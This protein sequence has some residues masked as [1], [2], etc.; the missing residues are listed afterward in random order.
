[1]GEIGNQGRWNN[2][3]EGELP[4]QAQ[5]EK[6]A[7]DGGEDQ[8]HGGSGS[9]R[10]QLSNAG[11]VVNRTRHEVADGEITIKIGPLAL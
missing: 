10:N 3:G 11:D 4:R 7:N 2:H 8:D 5:H 6:Q 9:A 1:M